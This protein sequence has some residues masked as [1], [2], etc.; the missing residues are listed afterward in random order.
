MGACHRRPLNEVKCKARVGYWQ[1]RRCRWGAGG[2]AIWFELVLELHLVGEKYKV[3][4]GL[5]VNLKITL[6][7]P[8]LE[9]FGRHHVLALPRIRLVYIPSCERCR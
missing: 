1:P 2:G 6:L 8:S 7:L 5:K 9:P 4:F 3:E